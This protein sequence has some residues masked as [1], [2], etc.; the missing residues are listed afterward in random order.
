[1]I[2]IEDIGM[3]KIVPKLDRKMNEVK[4]PNFIYPAGDE[5]YIH[6]YGDMNDVRNLYI[7]V[8]QQFIVDIKPFLPIVEE[9]LVDMVSGYDPGSLEERQ[10]IL[11][12][13]LA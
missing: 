5:I 12:E 13:C 10:A 1:M 7:P 3:P 4:A 8:E 2:P 9:R 11:R 6:I